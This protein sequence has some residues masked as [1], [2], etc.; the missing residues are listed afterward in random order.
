MV[1]NVLFALAILSNQRKKDAHCRYTNNI[2]V[3]MHTTITTMKTATTNKMSNATLKAVETIN[4]IK[5]QDER[6]AFDLQKLANAIYKVEAKSISH[7]YKQ[8]SALYGEQT[9]LG[10]VVRELT[11]A[12]LPT[13]KAFTTAYKGSPCLWYGF[14][15]LR[16]LNP[17]FKLAEKVKRQNKSEAKK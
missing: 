2:N 14:A 11:G 7:V 8:V 16:K 13:F 17:K 15:T 1:L 12:K 10:E 3:R 4:A 5:A 9:E 6:T